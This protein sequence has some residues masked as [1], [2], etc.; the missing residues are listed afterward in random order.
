M[1]FDDLTIQVLRNFSS[2]NPGLQFRTGN[3]LRTI[4]PSKTVFAKANL[5]TEIEGDFLIYDI[6]KLLGVISLFDQPNIEAEDKSLIIKES[7]RKVEYFY[8][9]EDTVVVPPNK[10]LK[11]KNVDVEFTLSRTDLKDLMKAT[12]VLS[13]PNIGVVGKDDKLILRAFDSKNPTSDSYDIVV[14]DTDQEFDVTFK[15]ENLKLLDDDYNVS[16]DLNSF[17]QFTSKVMTYS[18]A[19]ET[20]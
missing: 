13:L 5:T 16:I 2:I 18:I 6:S 12:G 9:A 8:A 1:H 7:N 20:T 4:S 15:V 19:M 3:I 10:D 11:Q 14:G 17:A